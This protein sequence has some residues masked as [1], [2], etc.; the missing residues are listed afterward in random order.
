[1]SLNHLEMFGNAP[2]RVISAILPFD[3]G[4]ALDVAHALYVYSRAVVHDAGEAY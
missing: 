2:W 1:M 4:D 3:T